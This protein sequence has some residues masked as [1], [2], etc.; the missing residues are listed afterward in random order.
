MIDIVEKLVWGLA[1]LALV[2]VGAY[3]ALCGG[4][5]TTPYI[6]ADSMVVDKRADFEKKLSDEAKKF[7]KM[8]AAPPKAE[9]RDNP[10]VRKK[11]PRKKE[12]RLINRGTYERV[13][14]RNS[15]IREAE[16]AQSEVVQ[17][18][19]GT[20]SLKVFNFD[21]TSILTKVGIEP[22]DVVDYI[23]GEK[24]DFSS[25]LE[26]SNLYDQCKKQLESGIPVVVDITR[27]GKTMQLIIAPD[28]QL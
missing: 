16:K 19:D 14:S 12:R 5:S 18:K 28:F 6:L 15:A 2:S 13:G 27:R 3:W 4:P 17:N 26:A 7:L 9:D 24:I 10:A 25:K 1:V 22:E 11:Q 20:N 8:Q 23:N 21:E